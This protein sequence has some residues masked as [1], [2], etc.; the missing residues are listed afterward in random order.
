MSCLGGEPQ[1]LLLAAC[2]GLSVCFDKDLLIYSAE[3]DVYGFCYT[4]KHTEGQRV[5]MS[6]PVFVESKY[7]YNVNADGTLSKT[8]AKNIL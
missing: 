2:D 6:M 7:I 8:L 1:I 5:D 3:G 4:D